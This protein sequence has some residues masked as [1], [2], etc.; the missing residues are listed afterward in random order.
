MLLAAGLLVVSAV[1]VYLGR[2]GYKDAAPTTRGRR[3]LRKATS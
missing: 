1:I 3:G 2:Y